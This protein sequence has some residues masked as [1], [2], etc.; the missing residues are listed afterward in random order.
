[1]KM[2]LRDTEDRLRGANICLIGVPLGENRH[3]EEA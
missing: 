1:M 3:S 2:K